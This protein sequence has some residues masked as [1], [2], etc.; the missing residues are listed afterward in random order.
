LKFRRYKPFMIILALFV[1]IYFA[2]GL[3]VKKFIDWFLKESASQFS[4]F[5]DTGLPIFDFVDIWQNL[6]FITFL[7]KY[8]LAFVVIISICLEYSNKTIKQNFIDGLS[9]RD[10]ILSKIG[11]IAFL[12]LLSGVLLTILGLVLGMLYSPVKSFPF[13]IQNMEFVLAHMLEVFAFLSFALFVATLIRRT[14]FAIVLFVFYATSIEPIVTAVMKYQYD[15]PVWY[16]PLKSISNIV[17]L[18]FEKYIFREVQDYVALQ[19]VAAAGAWTAIFLL[20]AFLLI[21]KRDV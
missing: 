6:A 17:R 19:D 3:S 5:V 14:G 16:F 4:F 15:L 12:T 8:I 1:L 11:L 9:R 21:K 13:V 18:P 7:F 2:I 10:F 20:L